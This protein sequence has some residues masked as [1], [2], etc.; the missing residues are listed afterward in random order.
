VLLRL[1]RGA[2]TTGLIGMSPEKRIGSLRILRP[3]FNVPSQRSDRVL[4]NPA[5]DVARRREQCRP[6]ISAQ[7]N[8]A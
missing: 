8:P 3:L 1:L 2:G 6:A 7:P 5:T 4:E